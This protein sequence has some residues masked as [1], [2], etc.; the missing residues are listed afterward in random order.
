MTDAQAAT[1][2]AT[3]I[4][5][6]I[7]VCLLLVPLA[8]GAL[9]LRLFHLQVLEHERYTTL[10]EANRLRVVPVPPPR[11]RIF[12]QDGVL[13][14]GHR[15]GY[16]LQ[17]VASEAGPTQVWLPRLKELVTLNEVH[18]ER[19]RKLRGRRQVFEPLV[20]KAD[21]KER[22][23]YRFV[24]HQHFFP[25]ISVVGRSQ[26]YYPR[27]LE[28]AHV[29]GY[30]S[31]LSAADLELLG[32]ERSRYVA[33][34]IIGK[35]GLERAYE[36][37]LHGR[38]GYLEEEVNADG[39]SLRVVRESPARPGRDLHLSLDAA[40]Q[41]EAQ[42]LLDGKRGAV[43]AIEPTTGRILALASQPSFDPNLFTVGISARLYRELL[44][45]PDRPLY[46]RALQGQYPPGSS[47]KPFYALAA[48][49]EEVR[50]LEQPTWCP[51][52]Y[53]IGGRRGR[54][55]HDWKR[56]GH[57]NM[58]MLPAITQSCDVYFYHL[59]LDLGIRSMSDSLR[60]F[61]FGERTRLRGGAEQPGL[62]P[63][64]EWKLRVRREPWRKGDTLNM[65]IGQGFL[66][67]TPLQLAAA[68]AALADRGVWRRPSLV[69]TEEPEE[70]E[71]VTYDPRHLHWVREGMRRVVH[72]ARGTARAVGRGL[73]Y[74]MAGKTGTAQVVK[75]TEERRRD[76]DVLEEL[77]DHAWF[78]AYAPFE[79]PR[80]ALVVLVEN[81]GSGSKGA[82]PLARRLLDQ[83]LA[84]SGES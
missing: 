8:I 17:V 23:V 78:I 41:F 9:L 59:A 82:A 25:G 38:E 76:K 4:Q 27:G 52:H 64:P 36:H 80:I 39:R 46:N 34:D 20:L 32:E 33:T 40:L 53:R 12:S 48:L 42:M 72:G 63:T 55:F 69:L 84:V 68:T 1:R 29:I 43:V 6:R 51:G 35:T 58:S 45:A 81:G 15:L 77:Q 19:Y 47:I 7:Y 11:G 22:E 3:R 21:L 79:K 44:D 57:G 62:V 66:L 60:R 13:L 65:G 31:R 74:E 37:L 18:L 14:A 30:V 71:A 50:G 26:R 28:T 75:L 73:T 70:P 56:G 2:A 5:R 54:V 49:H 16:D 10:S 61:G 67:V 24:V 83:Y